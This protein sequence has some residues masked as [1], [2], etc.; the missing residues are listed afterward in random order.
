MICQICGK[1]CVDTQGLTSHA[2]KKHGLT[3]KEYYDKFIRKPGE[4]ICPTCGKETKF[5]KFGRGYKK[6]C[7]YSC[8]SADPIANKQRY[9]TYIKTYFEKTGYKNSSQNPEV[10][11]KRFNTMR[12]NNTLMRS[13][14]EDEICEFIKTFYNDKILQNERFVIGNKELDIYL[15]N[16]NKAIEYNGTVWHA[17]PRFYKANDFLIQP[18]KIAQELWNRD[19]EKRILCESKNIKLLI[20]WE[21]D[22]TNNKDIVFESI[23]NFI[24]N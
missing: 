4:G 19:N 13:R 2:F 18:R 9:N 8:S 5:I 17:D 24:Y 23:K 16:L 14:A 10:Q 22:Y 1:E 3:S 6:H 12:L 21:Y 11:E 20:I 15:P 7:N